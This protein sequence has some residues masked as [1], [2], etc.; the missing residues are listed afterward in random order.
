[1]RRTIVSRATRGSSRKTF[2][3][4][5]G[6]CSSGTPIEIEALV[7]TATLSCPDFEPAALAK[8]KIVGRKVAETDKVIPLKDLHQSAPPFDQAACAKFLNH[9]IGV[10]GRYSAGIRDIGL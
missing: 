1:M 9:T 10:Y 7:R 2:V 4:S 6:W 5:P 3:A 8:V